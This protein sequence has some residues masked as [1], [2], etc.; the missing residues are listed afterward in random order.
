MEKLSKKIDSLLETVLEEERSFIEE[1]CL[2][3]EYDA[4]EDIPIDETDEVDLGGKYGWQIKRDYEYIVE[5]KATL[6]Q[7]KERIS[8]L[9]EGT[10]DK[11][12]HRA[13]KEL[14]EL[15]TEARQF[16]FQK[17]EDIAAANEVINVMNNVIDTCQNLV[18][19]KIRFV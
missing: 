16:N 15:I 7:L 18:G 1:L 11:K 19:K 4:I 13:R 5:K 6:I 9:A 14:E 10:D 2:D 12:K 3:E 17:R 8:V